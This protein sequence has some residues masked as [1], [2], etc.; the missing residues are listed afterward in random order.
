MSDNV[1]VNALETSL[2]IVETL[3]EQEHATLTELAQEVDL[4]KST[5]F[6]H[7]KTL[8]RNEYLVNDGGSYR[9][10]CRF[11]ELGAKARDYHDVYEI[12]RQEV[13]RLAAE[14]GEISALIIEEHGYG[15]FLHREEGTQAVHIDSYVGQRIYLHGAALGKAILASLP[16]E[17]VDGIVDQ[18]G[19][20]AL[21]PNTITDREELSAELDRIEGRGVALDDQERLNGLR[22]V[23]VPLTDADGNVLG[24]MSIA[25]PTSRVQDERFREEFPAKIKDAADVVELNVTYS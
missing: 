7:A 10:G 23:A 13:D 8:E 4:P 9:V 18:H 24:S 22:G 21:T 6:N 25:G 16:R 12:A 1:P 11:L 2:T 20:P 19:L 15:V 3:K 17:R 5:V 14:T